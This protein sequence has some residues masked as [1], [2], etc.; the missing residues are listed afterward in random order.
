M[1]ELVKALTA[2]TATRDSIW[3]ANLCK[4]HPVNRPIRRALGLREIGS[5]TQPKFASAEVDALYKEI[6][7]IATQHLPV[8][9]LNAL[10]L[11]W[12]AG[13]FTNHVSH[14]LPRFGKLWSAPMEERR[15]A[16]C[17]TSPL[18]V[19]GEDHFCNTDLFWSL[20]THR[21]L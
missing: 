20:R 13:T 4:S 6:Q 17:A 2:G 12:Y 19:A 15:L 8:S 10:R 7:R 11:A 21:E 3:K 14:L 9:D 5:L 16:S 1:A 18:L